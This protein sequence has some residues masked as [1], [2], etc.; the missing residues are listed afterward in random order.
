MRAGFYAS[1][2]SSV[3]GDCGLIAQVHEQDLGFLCVQYRNGHESNPAL[4]LGFDRLS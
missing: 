3:P 2:P 1:F 4:L